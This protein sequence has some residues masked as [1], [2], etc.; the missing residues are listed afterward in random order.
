[1]LYRW[2]YNNL[3]VRTDPEEA[4]DIAMKAIGIFGHTPLAPLCQATVGWRGSGSFSGLLAR[5]LPGRVGMAAGQDKDATAIL[6][7]I[8]LG[9][10]FT[11]IGTVT[12]KPQPGNEQPRL[13]RITE[14]KAF[15]NKMGFNNDGADAVAERLAELR[16]TKRGRAAVVG[17]N[18]GKN[19]WTSAQDAPKDYSIC[20]Q[21]L[22]R[23]ADYLVINVSSPNT[24]GLRDLQAVDS[25][26]EIA[27][28]TRQA[29]EKAAGRRVPVL[30][31]IAPDLADSDIA[32]VAQMVIDEDLDG[33]VATNTTIAHDYGEGGVSGAPVHERA[34]AVV[35][36]LRALLGPDRIII[37]VGGI[38]TV[39]DANRMLNAG[40]DLLEILTSFVYEGPLLPG[41]LNRA[42]A[43][44]AG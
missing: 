4:H 3:L 42:L 21:K 38:F 29:S 5:P 18:I 2:V 35:T 26:R 43:K 19:K 25:L 24:P 11:E 6:G 36:Q 10:A 37:G 17:V 27:R 23:Y 7:T 16:S 39:S 22:A 44:T 9:F 32:E 31:K 20:A 13:W 12:P 30:V 8:A 28:A 1:M 34:V 15:R 41:K 14:K 40:A 33:V